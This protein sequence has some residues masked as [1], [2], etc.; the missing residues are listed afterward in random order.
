MSVSLKAR[1]YLTLFAFSICF[2]ACTSSNTGASE[3]ST[4][5]ASGLDAAN[6][7]PYTIVIEQFAYVPARLDIP[8]GETLWI[9]NRDV[10]KHSVTSE[11]KAGDFVAGA[12]GGVQFDSG[13]VNPDAT[14]SLT[15]SASAPVGTVIPYFCTVHKSTMGE[16]QLTIQ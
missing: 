14:A 11:T 12:V 10:E 1:R 16:G 8:A 15:L 13:M 7:G 4:G 9:V 5:G 2:A 6:P 3:P